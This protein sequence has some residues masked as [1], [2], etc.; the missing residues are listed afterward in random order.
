MLS[1]FLLVFAFSLVTCL[2]LSI[3]VLRGGKPLQG[4]CGGINAVTGESQ[5]CTVCGRSEPCDKESVS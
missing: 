2:L 1:V 5:E 3:S 4:S